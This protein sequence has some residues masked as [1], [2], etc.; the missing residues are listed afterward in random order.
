MEEMLDNKKENRREKINNLDYL[1][2]ISKLEADKKA[3]LQTIKILME[4]KWYGKT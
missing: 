2:K 4:D 1:I 3:L